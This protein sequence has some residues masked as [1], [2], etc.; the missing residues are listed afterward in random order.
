MDHV[1]ENLP[2]EIQD[3]KHS[4]LSGLEDRADVEAI[5]ISPDFDHGKCMIVLIAQENERIPADLISR[6]NAL[7]HPMENMRARIYSVPYT[8]EELFRGNLF[9]LR[10]CYLGRLMYQAHPDAEVLPEKLRVPELLEKSAI[11]FELEQEKIRKIKAGIRFYRKRKDRGLAAFMGHQTLELQFRCLEHFAVGKS[12]ICHDLETHQD[13]IRPFLYGA[14]NLF[15]KENIFDIHL[16]GILNR[17]YLDAR[18]GLRFTTGKKELKRLRKKIRAMETEIQEIYE[19]HRSDCLKRAAKKGSLSSYQDLQ[20]DE[21]T[22]N[23]VQEV[24]EEV[25][26]ILDSQ[27]PILNL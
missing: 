23:K 15:S 18:Y 9:F 25:Y 22:E 4:V 6:V 26:R 17:S 13:Y 19:F 27:N 16:L 7:L 2:P 24:M 8:R 3:L 20:Q 5:Y 14:G 1:E 12:R 11:W 21:E 10:N